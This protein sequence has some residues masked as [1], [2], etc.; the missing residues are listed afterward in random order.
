[1]LEKGALKVYGCCT[2]PVFSGPAIE[3]IA[4]APF[5]EIVVTNTIPLTEGKKLPDI[6]VLSVAPLIG[7]AILRIHE[8]L[9]VSKLFEG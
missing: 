3:R 2:H 7:E 8:D 4:N 1:M 9:S 6:T 5:E